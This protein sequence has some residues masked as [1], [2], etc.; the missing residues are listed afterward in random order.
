[1]GRLQ[2]AYYG[3][4]VTDTLNHLTGQQ[5]RPPV[6]DFSQIEAK[7]VQLFFTGTAFTPDLR[8][9]IRL[10][11]DTRGLPALPSNNV[12]QT[13]GTFAPHGQAASTIGG[14]VTV[15]H[16]LRLFECWVAYDFHPCCWW[17][18][19]GEECCE[20]GGAKYAPTLSI[21]AGKIKPF[22]GLEEILGNQN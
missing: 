12:S 3:Y 1:R 11:G 4:K 20:D 18:G 8:Y 2:L 6:G 22:F 17:K 16:A 10:H 5:V 13:A 19:C 15:D 7:R 21:T 14:V 9:H